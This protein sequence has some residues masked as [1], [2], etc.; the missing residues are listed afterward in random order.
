[1]VAMQGYNS[2]F[3]V[4]LRQRDRRSGGPGHH[5]SRQQP[6][7]RHLRGKN[8]H[9]GALGQRHRRL[10]C[11]GTH[12]QAVRFHCAALGDQVGRIERQHPLPCPPRNPT[13]NV[14]R[15]PHSLSSSPPPGHRKTESIDVLDAVGSNIVV[16]TR[17]GEVM[18]VMPRLNE[19]VNEEWISDK[20]R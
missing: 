15:K 14:P 5:R 11:G 8:V 2:V 12:V 13:S 3:S 9:V 1:M 10:P 17:G 19:D 20:T 6:A 16:S 18:R 4:Q 7:D